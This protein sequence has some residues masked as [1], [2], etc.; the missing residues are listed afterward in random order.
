MGPA[1]GSDPAAHGPAVQQGYA[2]VRTATA[3]FRTLSAAVAAG[4]PETVAQCLS[5]SVHGAM[6]FHHMNRAL[7][8]R[9]LDVER[10]EILLYERRPDGSYGLN[11]VEYIVPYRVWPRDSTPPRL[12]DR[13]LLRSDPL[14][15]WYL[16]M[17]VWKSNPAGLFADWN[18]T[19]S[20]E[21]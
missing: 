13:D 1:A 12:M 9:Q 20:C 10:P 7:L 4:Y 6:G 2:R 14:Q 3:P 19:V 11:G 17:W 21:R 18:P 16:H 8:D 15:L 5:D